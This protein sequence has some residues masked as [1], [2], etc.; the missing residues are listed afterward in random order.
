MSTSS[1]LKTRSRQRSSLFGENTC[2]LVRL[3]ALFHRRG[4][5][6]SLSSALPG[7]AAVVY[8]AVFVKGTRDHPRI[9]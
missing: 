8:R 1:L 7:P 3:D 5:L 4:K 9:G 2:C 6:V